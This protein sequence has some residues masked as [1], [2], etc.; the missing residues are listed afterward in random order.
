MKPC[1]ALVFPNVSSSQWACVQKKAAAHGYP[2][3]SDSGSMAGQ[4]FT[5]SWLYD[6]K[7]HTLTFICVQRPNWASC[8]TV[9]GAIH[10]FI[11]RT[12]CL[13]S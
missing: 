8:A 12:E 5:V 4:G 1:A 7:A 11:E 6:S 10:D 3:E 13:P 9:N 2:M